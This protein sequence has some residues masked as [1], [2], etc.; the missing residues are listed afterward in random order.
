VT[1]VVRHLSAGDLAAAELACRSILAI[2]PSQISASNM[3]GAVLLYQERYL[4]AQAVFVD[5]TSREPDVPSHW[6][7]LGTVRRGMREFDG[8]L[9]AYARAAELGIKEPDFYFNIGLIH[10]DRGDFESARVVLK[11]ARE[12]NP[13][14]AEITL[15]YA[16]VC[17]R[18]LQNDAAAAALAGWRSMTGLRPNA[19][20][21]IAR[22]LIK[23]G[24]QYEGE[25]ALKTLGRIRPPMQ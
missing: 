10:V 8:A 17:Y 7:N 3:L 20:S 19:L 15:R 23:L 16:D 12:L 25:Q 1:D 24:L 21:E 6:I 11:K 5:L 22:L 14:D 9:V 13:A 4:E 18:L 2:T